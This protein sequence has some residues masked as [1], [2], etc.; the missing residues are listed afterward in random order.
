[1]SL[2]VSIPAIAAPQASTLSKIE[3][4]LYGFEYTN[5]TSQNRV[6]RLEKTIYGKSSTGDINK[7]I[8]KL[9]ADISADVIGLEIP[10][11]EDTFNEENNRDDI[12]KA[13]STVNYPVVDEIEQKLF[14]KTYKE[15]DFHT[16]IVTIERKLFNKIYDVDDY[17]TRMDRIKAEVMP[18]RVDT[19]R[20][21]HEYRD[22]RDN[23]LNSDSISGLS[24]NRF[25]FNMPF[26]QRNYTRPYANYGDMTG[27]AA[28]IPQG[29]GNLND[30]LAQLEFE[31]F[32]TEF[33]NED[34][35]TRI[36]RLNS[37]SKAKK[38]SS[39]YDSNKFSQRM[40]TAMEIGAMILMILAMVL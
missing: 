15:R 26:G 23:D 7:R 39:K 11:V 40:S 35:A 37:V 6:E 8:K 22:N 13:D 27:G 12:A 14:N 19:D 1:M 29:G 4:D 2:S 31:T 24:G 5:D 10:P 9:S 28:S 34:T 36:K 32:G 20:F 38:S 21:A 3:N 25:G 17:S 33:S 18:E 30:E 16:R